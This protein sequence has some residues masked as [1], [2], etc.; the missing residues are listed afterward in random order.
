[1]NRDE[2][3]KRVCDELG[4]RVDDFGR[5]AEFWKYIDATL[6]VAAEVA[7]AERFAGDPH[8]HKVIVH[9]NACDDVAHALEALILS[10]G[11]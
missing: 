10:G 5:K 3:E 6:K 11:K 2:F 1:M 4:M 7:L 8:D 9:N